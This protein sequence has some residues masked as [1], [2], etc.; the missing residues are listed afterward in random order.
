MHIQ[1]EDGHRN[2]IGLQR[3]MAVK[4]TTKIVKELYDE[5]YAVDGDRVLD[6]MAERVEAWKGDGQG[7]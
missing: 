3:A 2:L 7:S 4:T 5:G 6:E 1:T